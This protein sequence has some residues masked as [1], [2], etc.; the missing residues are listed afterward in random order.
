MKTKSGLPKR[1]ALRRMPSFKV[2]FR[3][4]NHT[5][6]VLHP[7]LISNQHVDAGLF[8]VVSFFAG[9]GGLDLGFLGGFKFHDH[10]YKHLPFKILAAYDNDEKAVEAYRLNLA[11][12]AK[13]QDLKLMNMSEAPKADVL[14]GGFPCQDFSSCGYKRGFAG[15][16]GRLYECMVEY[17]AEH[18]PAL[19]VGEN[20]PLLKGMKNGEYL[21]TIVSDLEDTGYRVR[22]WF[23]NCPD[24]GLGAS[25]KRIFIIG[26]RDDID[27][28]PRPPLP[29]HL[30]APNYIDDIIGDLID[31]DDESVTNQSQ[32]FVATK[33]TAG[34]GQGDQKSKA[35]DFG[36]A[37]RA[38]AKAR[39]HFH[40]QLDRRLTVRELARLQSFPDEFVFPFAAGPNVN[41][42]GNAVPPIVGH[43]VAHSMAEFLKTSSALKDTQN[44]VAA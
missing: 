18:R 23:L 21:R 20:V 8:S 27:G 40:Y 7:T 1:K 11:D 34:A 30:L 17:M 41:L 35:G 31:V 26:V 4:N 24:Y 15:E 33:A 44:E 28:F 5:Q 42:I 22:H 32:Y 43:A 6:D 29:S 38:N 9:C 37:V 13:V 10:T 19:V 12:H 39:I 36:Y 16:R 3:A 25:R 14:L 2:G